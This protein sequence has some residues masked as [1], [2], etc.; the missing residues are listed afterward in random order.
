MRPRFFD[1][2]GAVAIVVM[3]AVVAVSVV[4]NTI[5]LYRLERG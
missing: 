2:S 5:T 3:A 1:V 4:R